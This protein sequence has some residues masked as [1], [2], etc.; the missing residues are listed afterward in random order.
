MADHEFYLST[1]MKLFREVDTD[2]DGI[3]DT[4][5]FLTLY[6]RMNISDTDNLFEL[7]P[8]TEV[9]LINILDVLD[10]HQCDKIVLSDIVK[11]F[12]NANQAN[13][14]DQFIL[15]TFSSNVGDAFEQ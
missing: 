7:S 6:K 13:K 5:N 15:N 3:I 2:Q 4:E 10:P 1:F 9:E 14:S 12:K 8:K 11:L